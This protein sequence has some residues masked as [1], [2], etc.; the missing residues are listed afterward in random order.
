MIVNKLKFVNTTLVIISIF[1]LYLFS[2]LFFKNLNVLS[3]FG[4]S[5]IYFYCLLGIPII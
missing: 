4:V 3:D 5:G 1:W 2:L